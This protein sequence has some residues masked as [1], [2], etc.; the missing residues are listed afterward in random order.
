MKIKSEKLR[1]NE[2]FYK[3][4]NYL[5]E[6]NSLK[7]KFISGIVFKVEDTNINYLEPHRFI[8]EPF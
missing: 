8:I 1:I 7:L 5:C 4:L 3:K 2:S 6:F